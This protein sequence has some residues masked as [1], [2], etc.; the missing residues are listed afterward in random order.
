MGWKINTGIVSGVALWAGLA[1]M[2]FRPSDPTSI[3]QDLTRGQIKNLIQCV[4]PLNG[5]PWTTPDEKIWE[6]FYNAAAEVSVRPAKRWV[7]IGEFRRY[8]WP[9]G[10]AIIGSNDELW[11]DDI[12]T[13]E[14]VLD[15]KVPLKKGSANHE[16]T[17]FTCRNGKIMKKTWN[18]DWKKSDWDE[19]KAHITML[20]K[21]LGE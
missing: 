1:S 4:T 5:T 6:N 15:P 11:G 16:I 13:F 9:I 21:F 18:E 20:S 7:N 10:E 19:L 14:F 17:Q 12:V 3:Q 8:N 2:D